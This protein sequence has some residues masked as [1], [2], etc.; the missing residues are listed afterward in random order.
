MLLT[1]SAKS[2]KAHFDSLNSFPL[3]LLT[4]LFLYSVSHYFLH[5]GH[6]HFKKFSYQSLSSQ[7]IHPLI[8]SARPNVVKLLFHHNMYKT[9]K[10]KKSA[11]MPLWIHG[12]APTALITGSKKENV[13]KGTKWVKLTASLADCVSTIC[14]ILQH[15]KRQVGFLSFTSNLSLYCTVKMINSLKVH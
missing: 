13:L 9:E 6:L 14:L 4:C 12:F 7:S 10:K 3:D 2:V 11:Q 1:K 8:F 5:K 15:L